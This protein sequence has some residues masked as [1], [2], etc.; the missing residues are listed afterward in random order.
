MKLVAKYTLVLVAAIAL[1]L[2]MLTVYRMDS[3][4]SNFENDMGIDHRV[5]GRVLVAIA[6][7]QWRDQGTL[8]G[9]R[10]PHL[11]QHLI[12]RANDA[13]GP[14]RFAWQVGPSA[15][16]EVRGEEG[17]EYV[18]HFPVRVDGHVVGTIT[19]RESLTDTERLVHHG[20]VISVL[21]VGVIVGLSLVAS[22]VLGRWLVGKPISQLVDKARRVGRREFAGAVELRRAD[23][24]GELASAMNAMSGELAQ[25][26]HQI[27]VETDARV[28]AVEQMRHADR[29]STVG[30]LAA[31]VAHELGT[32]LSI[33]AGYAQMIASREVS[34]EAALDSA[35]AI[36]REATRMSRIVRQLLDFARRRGPEGTT[37]DVKMIA[38]RCLH[39]LA[40]MAVKAGVEIE[41]GVPAG[42]HV[43]IDENNFQQVLTNLLVNAL[44]AMPSGGALRVTAAHDTSAPP[45]EPARA[46]APC[47]RVSVADTGTG[48]APDVLAHI[49]E[50]FF[51]T[52]QPGDGTGLGLAVIYGIVVDHQG[53]ITVDTSERGTTFSIFLQEAAA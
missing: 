49:F 50:P 21:S 34:D 14:T 32:P 13:G 45:D 29:L 7:D 15:G 22:L 10:G 44:Q 1:A 11:I 38:E 36:D 43:L 53:W 5:V 41:L 4:R 42:L 23:E 8:G 35:R 19:V 12:D 46:P 20:I 33:V 3:D 27:T 48:I 52:K 30:K 37:S 17:D 24:L 47:V 6:A 18:S 2:S 28:R 31:G 51:T 40:P 9:E 39:L 16:G 25:A 26:L